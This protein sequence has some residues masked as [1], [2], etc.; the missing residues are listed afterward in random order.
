MIKFSKYLFAIAFLCFWVNG[1]SSDVDSSSLKRLIQFEENNKKNANGI[2]YTP[3]EEGRKTATSLFIDSFRTILELEASFGYQFDSF[4][5]INAI[6]SED[7]KLRV[8][9]FHLILNNELHY[10]YGFIQKKSKT[11]IEVFELKDTANILPND[12]LFNEIYANEWIGGMY[13]N[14]NQF[15]K[16]GITYYTVLAYDGDTKRSSKKFMDV[17]WFNKDGE[18]VFGAPLF[19]MDENDYEPQYRFDLEYANEVKITMNFEES[20]RGV[21]YIV[22]S[23]LQPKVFE[24]KGMKEHYYPDGTY[25][26]FILKKKKW[27]MYKHL[28]KFNFKGYE[29]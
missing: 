13:Y 20:K 3:I 5:C 28:K 15:K 2:L 18:L 9:T 4:K 23:H 14:I 7:K 1:N 10:Y 16:K 17:I 25:D 27:I 19:H 6:T 26:Y 11:G 24:L 22:F 8:Y 29:D 21:K 12:Y